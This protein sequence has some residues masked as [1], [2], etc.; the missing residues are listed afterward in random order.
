MYHLYS[1]MLLPAD[2]E[3]SLN[4]PFRFARRPQTAERQ[5]RPWDLVHQSTIE[6]FFFGEKR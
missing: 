4:H 2:T 5:P 6:G 3:T 1:L